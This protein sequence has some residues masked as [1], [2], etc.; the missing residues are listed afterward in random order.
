MNTPTVLLV[1]TTTKRWLLAAASIGTTLWALFSA[2]TC[3]KSTHPSALAKL[4]LPVRRHKTPVCGGKA[5]HMYGCVCAIA[6]TY[7]DTCFRTI[8]RK[9]CAQ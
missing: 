2:L 8:R 9:A 3:V 5:R 7:A 4:P 6:Y 1:L